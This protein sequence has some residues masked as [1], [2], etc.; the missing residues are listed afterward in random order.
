[1]KTFTAR[2]F[3]LA[4]RSTLIALIAA[5]ATFGVIAFSRGYSPV[6]ANSSRLA[7]GRATSPPAITTRE[8]VEAELITIRPTGFE[9]EEIMRPA[10]RFLLAFDNE[11]GLRDLVFRLEREGGER[12]VEMRPKRKS[13]VGGVMD[14]PPGLYLVTEANHPEWVFRLRLTSP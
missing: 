1:M 2:S 14:L 5:C 6:S 12:I 4:S 13:D 7:F 10:G 11:S 3:R 8:D 9:P